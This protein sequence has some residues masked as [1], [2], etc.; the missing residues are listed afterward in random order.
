VR[1]V[2]LRE[3]EKYEMSFRSVRAWTVGDLAAADLAPHF[4]STARGIAD[5]VLLLSMTTLCRLV[6]A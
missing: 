3:K 1:V 5:E 6:V 2:S 4:L